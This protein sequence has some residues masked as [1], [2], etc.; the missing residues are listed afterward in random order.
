MDMGFD[1]VD[2]IRIGEVADVVTVNNSADV[3]ASINGEP[4][5]LLTMQKQ[6]GYSTGEVSDRIQETFD[7]LSAEE[8]GPHFTILMDQGIY[9][10]MIIN[11]VVENMLFG[12]LLAIL[13]LIVF[14]KSLRLRL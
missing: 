11:S 12:A 10:D 9:M 3:Y 4:G 7:S 6:T 2:P 14:M 8:N 5:I 1:D 13:V